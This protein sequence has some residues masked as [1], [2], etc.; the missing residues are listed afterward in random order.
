MRS[1]KREAQKTGSTKSAL[2]ATV[3]RFLTDPRRNAGAHYMAI[4]RCNEYH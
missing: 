3:G 1:A 4:V 2:L